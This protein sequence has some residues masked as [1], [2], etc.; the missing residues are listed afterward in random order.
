[1]RKP[2]TEHQRNRIR[3]KILDVTKNIIEDEGFGA[4]SMRKV[5]HRVGFTPGNIYQYFNDK[6][7]L[8]QNALK[9][10]Y[11]EIFRT[12]DKP[13]DYQEDVTSQIIQR[14]I[15]YSKKAIQMSGY[16]RA[17]ML[18]QNKMILNATAIINAQNNQLSPALIILK[19][20]I[21]HGVKR[22]EFVECDGLNVAK[23]LWVSNFGLVLK[24]IVEGE[25]NLERIEKLVY[26]HLKIIFKG[27]Q[28][29]EEN[30]ND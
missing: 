8:I 11:M 26:E 15:D 29:K 18:S 16:Y 1:M 23:M 30:G 14:F 9:D 3:K 28:C 19:E 20:M 21:E 5:A 27:I 10:G 22:K 13:F 17:V 6:E 25:N 24:M 7:T 12:V 2:I 4:V